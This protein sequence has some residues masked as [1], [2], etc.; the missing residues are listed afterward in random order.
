VRQDPARGPAHPPDIVEHGRSGF[1]GLG[2]GD[3]P[4]SLREG[5]TGVSATSF[6]ATARSRLFPP[7]IG[8][9][10]VSV[11]DSSGRPYAITVESAS[12]PEAAPRET[13][14]HNL[15]RF[16]HTVPVT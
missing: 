4:S 2:A 11:R 13:M 8:G 16:G 7:D 12:L 6:D 14:P 1:T 3:K 5:V 10:G 9:F 15:E